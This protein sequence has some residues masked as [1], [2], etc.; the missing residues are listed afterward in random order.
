MM[1]MEAHQGWKAQ[2]RDIQWAE[3]IGFELLAISVCTLLSKGKHIKVYGDNWGV[4][5]GWWKKCSANK[6][7]NYIFHC[8]LELSEKHNRAIHTRYVPSTQNPADTP[9]RGHYP[10]LSHH[11]NPIPIP[12]EIWPFL[13]DI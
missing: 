2:G 10:P 3:A 6:P 8:I 11:L 1:C 13:L 5:K 7:T 9:S 12:A 4:I